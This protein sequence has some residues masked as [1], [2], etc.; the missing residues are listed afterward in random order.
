MIIK[1]WISISLQIHTI[2]TLR[3]V[4][5]MF[6]ISLRNIKVLRTYIYFTSSLRFFC[7]KLLQNPSV[8]IHNTIDFGKIFFQVFFIF[9]GIHFQ[10]FIVLKERLGS[11]FPHYRNRNHCLFRVSIGV[12]EKVIILNI[13]FI[14]KSIDMTVLR[15]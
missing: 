13:I 6:Q 7:F 9:F 14:F 2:G 12:M 15:I 1:K 11:T 4:G 5:C 8:V 10:T 3:R